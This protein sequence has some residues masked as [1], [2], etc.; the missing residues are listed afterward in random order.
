MV[1]IFNFSG[2]PGEESAG[3]SLQVTQQIVKIVKHLGVTHKD[4]EE[5]TEI[6][7]PAVRKA[8][9]MTEYAIL[10]I[11]L[12]LSFFFI[13]HAVR[14]AALSILIAFA[15]ACLDE[16]HQLFVQGRGGTFMDVCVDMTG[17]VFAVA[18]VLFI[19]SS[20]QARQ[21]SKNEKQASQID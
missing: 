20:W 14:S 19:Y 4:T 13:V 12:F 6:L 1:V 5:L 2:Q 17:V 21:F 3:L 11:L 9:H 18:L 16:T 15:Y 7:H 8:A 10:Y